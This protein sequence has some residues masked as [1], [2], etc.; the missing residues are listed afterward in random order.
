V[1]GRAVSCSTSAQVVVAN[2]QNEVTKQLTLVATIF[3]PLSFI[4]KESVRR[5]QVGC[6]PR[7]RI[8]ARGFL[9]RVGLVFLFV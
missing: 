3:L 1:R 8:I 2:R 4:I 9:K 5:A 7:P 6:P